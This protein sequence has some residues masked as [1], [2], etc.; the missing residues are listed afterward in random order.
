VIG[1]GPRR[2]DTPKPREPT[3]DW[4]RRRTADGRMVGGDQVVVLDPEL[5]L[6]RLA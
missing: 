5:E 2:A 3:I 4:R 6:T 1:V